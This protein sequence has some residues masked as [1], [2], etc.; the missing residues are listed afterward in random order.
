MVFADCAEP[1]APRGILLVGKPDERAADLRRAHFDLRQRVVVVAHYALHFVA[2]LAFDGAA[3]LVGVLYL[4]DDLLRVRFQP[5]RGEVAPHIVKRR[6]LPGDFANPRV[7]FGRD[8]V[9]AAENGRDF[10]GNAGIRV[11]G[12]VD[13]PTV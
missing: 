5:H 8:L 13:K 2:S 12:L 6:E 9:G 11:V 4:L 7:H 10:A 3:H 1:L